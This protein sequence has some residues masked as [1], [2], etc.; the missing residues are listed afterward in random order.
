MGK[1]TNKFPAAGRKIK[2]CSFRIPEEQWWDLHF[3]AEALNRSKGDL[4]R[5]GI[6]VVIDI[7]DHLIR[8]GEKPDAE[9]RSCLTS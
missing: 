1:K 9:L 5:E 4:I 2:Q 7:Y 3:I 6:S 8:E